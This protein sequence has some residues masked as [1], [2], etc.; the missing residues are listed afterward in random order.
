MNYEFLDS[1]ILERAAMCWPYSLMTGAVRDECERIVDVEQP[2]RE[3]FRILDGRLQALRK[4]GK[5]A[6]TS[7]AGWALV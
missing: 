6:F 4:A 7:K 2:G 1:L 5:I 3:S